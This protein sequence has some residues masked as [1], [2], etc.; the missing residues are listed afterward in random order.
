MS[1]EPQH[2]EKQAEVPP[3][4]PVEV[5]QRR[6]QVPQPHRA[7]EAARHDH[8]TGCVGDSQCPGISCVAFTRG[9]QSSGLGV[10]GLDG[11]IRGAA[12]HDGL[13]ALPRRHCANVVSVACARAVVWGFVTDI[14]LSKFSYKRE[15]TEHIMKAHTQDNGYVMSLT[16]QH[17]E[18]LLRLDAPQ[19][20][21]EVVVALLSVMT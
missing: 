13:R 10:P 6:V 20:H 1:T 9:D 3:A 4:V 21:H 2:T 8:R 5:Q 14:E 12:D 11:S 16:F 18:E 19:P 17:H 15:E 7:V